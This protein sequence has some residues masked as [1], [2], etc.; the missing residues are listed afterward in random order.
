MNPVYFKDSTN[1]DKLE[2][3][4]AKPLSRLQST[5]RNGITND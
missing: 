2:D 5:G 1:E 3:M 4:F